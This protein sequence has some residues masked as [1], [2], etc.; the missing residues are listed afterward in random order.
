MN[1]TNILASSLLQLLTQLCGRH[2]FRLLLFLLV[3]I[4]VCLAIITQGKRSEII[5]LEMSKF[6]VVIVGAEVSVVESLGLGML[7]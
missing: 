6:L 3:A 2:H 4:G 1:M 7:S 5:I